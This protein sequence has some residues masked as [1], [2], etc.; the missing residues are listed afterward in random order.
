MSTESAGDEF[1]E[2]AKYPVHIVA[3]G[4]AA[5]SAAVGAITVR[6]ERIAVELL[7]LLLLLLLLRLQLQVAASAAV[8]ACAGLQKWLKS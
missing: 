1:S 8:S 4:R 7:L 2:L 6:V 3:R 5:T